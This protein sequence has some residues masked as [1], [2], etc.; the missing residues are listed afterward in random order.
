MLLLLFVWWETRAAQ[1]LLPFA[2][3]GDRNFA[4][5]NL[6]SSIIGFPFAMFLVLSIYLQSVLGF[7]AIQAGLTLIPTSLGLMVVGPIAGR[8]SDRI[9]GKETDRKTDRF[10]AT[11]EA[12]LTRA[13]GVTA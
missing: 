13:L 4:V 3:F 9:N 12:Q 2:L 6:T 1:P 5:A 11:H 8:L 7:S 10:C